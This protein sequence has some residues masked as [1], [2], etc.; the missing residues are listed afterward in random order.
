MAKSIA[1]LLDDKRLEAI[2]GSGLEDKIDKM[3]GGALNA[4]ILEIDDDKAKEVLDAFHTARIDSRGFITDVPIAFNRTLFE[5]IAKSKS[6]GT[7]AIDGVLSR[8]SEIKEA[9]AKESEY[10]PAPDM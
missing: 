10:L 9:A 5:E 7:E 2:K 1:V 4:F 8:V 3:F 6:L